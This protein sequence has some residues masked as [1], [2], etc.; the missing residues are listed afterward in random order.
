MRGDKK[1]INQHRVTE[2]IYKAVGEM[3][4]LAWFDTQELLI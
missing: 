1:Y 4:I 3:W 2:K